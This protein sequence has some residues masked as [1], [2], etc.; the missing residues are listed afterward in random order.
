M[1]RHDNRADTHAFSENDRRSYS[2][3]RH[4]VVNYFLIV[5]WVHSKPAASRVIDAMETFGGVACVTSE[6]HV[7][8]RE[9]SQ[10]HDHAGAATF[11]TWLNLHNPFQ[12]ASP[13]LASLTSGVVASAAVNCD[14]AL[15]VG[16]ASMKAMEG[17]FFSE[18]YLQ[19]LNDV[20]SLA[21]VTKAV[22]LGSM[23][24]ALFVDCS[25]RKGNKSSIVAV[26]DDL[27]P[28]GSQLTS[29]ALYT[30]AGGHRLQRVGWRHAATYGHVCGQYKQYTTNMYGCARVVVD[31]Y[32]APNTKDAEGS[33]RVASS[34]KFS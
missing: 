19:R 25:L 23:P 2:W 12:R 30:I 3:A 24:P 11:V 10:R 15:S 28:R 21:S 9:S 29:T 18:I 16:E 20:R 34:K 4:I 1:D 6:K 33:R 14:D 13:L 26:L 22:K 32:G 31:G 8:S 27:A 5:K 17:K 7:D